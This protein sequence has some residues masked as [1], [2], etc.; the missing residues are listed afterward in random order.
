MKTE[1][2]KKD[3]I[4]TG[5]SPTD[6]LTLA[7]EK[8]LDV[9]KLEKLMALQQQWE[10]KQAKKAF[11]KAMS[12]FQSK[13]PVLKKSKTVKF[14]AVQY[15]YIPLGQITAQ[16]KELLMECGLSYRW[17]TKYSEGKITITC[18]VSHV[19]GHSE[20]NSMMA[21]KD[22]SGAKNDIQQIGSTMTY[23][24]RY[25]LIGALGI[26]SA[27]NDVDG[28]ET[29]RKEIKL[30][31]KES[32]Q[33]LI[34]SKIEIDNFEKADELQ[35]KGRLFLDEQKKSG[36]NEKDKKELAAHITLKFEKLTKI[37]KQETEYVKNL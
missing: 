34:E 36:L 12:E 20:Q 19:D 26:S 13:C 24:Q 15:K 4:A 29:P 14:N 27:D 2:V 8:N 17:E 23:L 30:S 10:D 33:L 16:I 3:N 1:T 9:E 37:E 35:K 31:I 7:V 22:N 5:F 11:L 28:K 25:T 18:I 21:G 6:L 32:T